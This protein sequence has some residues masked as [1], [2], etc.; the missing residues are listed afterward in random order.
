M[1]KLTP[2][3]CLAGRGGA[4]SWARRVRMRKKFPKQSSQSQKVD[5]DAISS[6]YVAFVFK[7]TWNDPS[8]IFLTYKMEFLSMSFFH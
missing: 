8:V 6:V 1:T 7:L 3:P 5:G 4:L 2:P